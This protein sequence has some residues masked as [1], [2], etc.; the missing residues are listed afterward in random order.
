MIQ[1]MQIN[2]ILF[3]WKM[4]PRQYISCIVARWKT[5]PTAST[6]CAHF[7]PL[8]LVWAEMY[9]DEQI[10]M[11]IAFLQQHEV[12]YGDW[13]QM[14]D[15]FEDR[16]IQD[17]WQRLFAPEFAASGTGKIYTNLRFATVLSTIINHKAWPPKCIKQHGDSNLKFHCTI[18][19][20]FSP[21]FKNLSF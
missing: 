20:Q 4:I 6:Y 15:Q 18:K 12:T 8:E 10:Q 16:V 11:A 3:L 21:H 9:H 19:Q 2:P 1:R 17:G 14:L 7:L 5:P 13:D